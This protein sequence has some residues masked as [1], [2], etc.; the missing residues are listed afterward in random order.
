LID[1]K[2]AACGGQASAQPATLDEWLMVPRDPWP[3]M[4]APVCVRVNDSDGIWRGQMVTL[5]AHAI[6]AVWEHML[7]NLPKGQEQ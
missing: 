4:L 3:Q 7:R 2:S 6:G 5:D 1:D